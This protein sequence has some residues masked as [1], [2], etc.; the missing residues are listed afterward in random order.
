MTTYKKGLIARAPFEFAEGTAG[1]E[2]PVCIVSVERFNQTGDLLLAMITSRPGLVRNPGFADVVLQDW[3]Q[4]GLA[5]ASVLRAGRLLTRTIDLL[6]EPVGE[7]TSVDLESVDE[8]LRAVLG[9]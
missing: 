6:T 1:K 3:D 8:A 5:V 4:E 2:R 7:L 9:L